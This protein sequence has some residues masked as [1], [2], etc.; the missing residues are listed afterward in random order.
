[1]SVIVSGTSME[2]NFGNLLLICITFSL[3][4]D[5]TSDALEMN[6]DRILIVKSLHKMSRELAINLFSLRVLT[7]RHAVLVDGVRDLI[8]AIGHNLDAFT[9][10]VPRLFLRTLRHHVELPNEI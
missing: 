5:Q 1:M 10:F 4:A 3:S 9:R 2:I 7:F 8:G 6:I